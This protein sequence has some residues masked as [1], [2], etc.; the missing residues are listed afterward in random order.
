MSFFAYLGYGQ[1]SEGF[2]GATFPPSGWHVGDNGIGLTRSWTTT[3]ATGLGWVHAGAKSA[4]IN[5]ENVTGIAEDWLVTPLV[6]VP[7]NGQLSFFARSIADGEQGSVYKVKISTTSQT[8]Q[9][10]FVD[11]V[12][13]PYTELDII[14]AH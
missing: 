10:S 5:K 12:T 4:I 8:D 3:T 14:N 13:P 1:I 6:N 7:V 2:E 11:I 9:T